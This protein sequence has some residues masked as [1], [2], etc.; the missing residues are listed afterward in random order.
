[1]QKHNPDSPLLIGDIQ[2]D[3]VIHQAEQKS[4]KD[5]QMSIFDC[6]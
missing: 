1:M 6:M 5:M 4:W 3:D 2:P